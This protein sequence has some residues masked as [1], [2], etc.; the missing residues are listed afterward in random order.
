MIK[1]LLQKGFALKNKGHYKH[2]IEVLYK[3]LEL[4]N[5]SSELLLEI[6][7]LYYRIHNE[8]KALNYIE[9]ILHNSPQH[10]GALKLLEQIF[11]N[12]GAFAEA[13]QAAK[14]IYCISNCTEDLVQV[15]KYL[16]QQGK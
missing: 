6:A 13:E 5:T 14:N 12:K 10:I 7:D 2:A 8:E 11:I 9:Q 4:D 15:F 3:A 1:E 16:N